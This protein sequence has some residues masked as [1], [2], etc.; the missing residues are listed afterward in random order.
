MP[1]DARKVRSSPS[2]LVSSRSLSKNSMRTSS[3]AGRSPARR[4]GVVSALTSM[5]SARQ[6]HVAPAP[7]VA[8]SWPARSVQPAAVNAAMHTAAA[9]ARRAR[10]GM[11]RTGAFTAAAR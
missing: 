2:A 7:A 11:L 8:T 5:R 1:A 9:M 6:R 10:R 4:S 3:D